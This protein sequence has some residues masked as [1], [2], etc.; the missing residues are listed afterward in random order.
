ML[1]VWQ[2]LEIRTKCKGVGVELGPRSAKL[3]DVNREVDCVAKL[4]SLKEELLQ[5]NSSVHTYF[6][7]SL[8]GEGGL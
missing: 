2:N 4:K 1:P 8:L 3:D 5:S 7:S 6:S